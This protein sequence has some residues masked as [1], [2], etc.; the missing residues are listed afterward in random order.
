MCADAEIEFVRIS[1]L[2]DLDE[3]PAFDVLF[4]ILVL[5]H[6]PPPVIAHII[7]RL[8]RGLKPGGVAYF[9]VPTF[10]AGY[11]FSTKEYLESSGQGMEMHVLPQRYIFP[12]A[13]RNGCEVIEV[14]PDNMT[15]SLDFVS[16]TFLLQKRPR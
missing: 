1:R 13:G 14:G 6:N 5:Q 2:A 9:Q 10:R 16:T 7:D 8:L 12:I 3:L 4:S 11:R 15:W